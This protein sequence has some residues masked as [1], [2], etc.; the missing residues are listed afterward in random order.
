MKKIISIVLV[1]L[2]MIPM[3]VLADGGAPMYA[4]YDAYISDSGGASLYKYEK[5]KY[6]K[7][8]ITLPYNYEFK[9]HSEE[10]LTEGEKYAYIL[11]NGDEYYV[12]LNKITPK[13]EEYTLDDFKKEL[14]EDDDYDSNSIEYAFDVED[15]LLID[16]DLTPKKGPSTIYGKANGSFKKEEKV[17]KKAEVDY[18]LYVEG[19]S[20]SGW[21]NT[22][23]TKVMRKGTRTYWLLEDVVPFETYNLNSAKKASITIPKNEKFN[24]IYSY[25]E[26]KYDE[27]DTLVYSYEVYRLMYNNKPYYIDADKVK[28]AVSSYEEDTK[29]VINARTD[30]YSTIGGSKVKTISVNSPAIQKYSSINYDSWWFYVESEGNSC[31]VPSNSFANYINDKIMVTDDVTASINNDGSADVS[32]PANTVFKDY[33]YYYAKVGTYYYVDYK[34]KKYWIN[35]YD[36]VANYIGDEWD[37]YTLSVDVNLYDKPNGKKLDVVIPEGT[38][39]KIRYDYRSYNGKN[40]SGYDDY[41]YWYYVDTNQYTGWLTEEESD[42]KKFKE[43]LAAKEETVNS[44]EDADEFKEYKKIKRE[45]ETTDDEPDE[46]VPSNKLS[47]NE[48]IGI[49]CLSAG[50]LTLLVIAIISLVNKK[51]KVNQNTVSTPQQVE[52]PNPEEKKDA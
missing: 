14:M 49:C 31:W 11:Y 35:N 19:S 34:G 18:W 36:K 21:I 47:T 17:V 33:N 20:V 50:V 46:I 27:N 39:I 8:G 26:S 48:L 9:V 43:Q 40:S 25:Y 42:M 38:D 30:C 15:V 4:P 41:I 1:I 29:G 52:T 12:N 37:E 7:S 3:L 16:G 51:K 24:D 10:E 22:E 32:I 44:E 2:L 6:V 45:P 13:K 28:M 23:D 5:E